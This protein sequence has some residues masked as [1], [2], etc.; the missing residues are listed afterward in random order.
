[1]L[2]IQ[3]YLIPFCFVLNRNC[4]VLKFDFKH[5]I[6]Y[7]TNEVESL[8]SGVILIYVVYFGGEH[9]YPPP[10]PTPPPQKKKKRNRYFLKHSNTK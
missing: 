1:M 8:L 4:F 6:F 2:F 5:I 7:K 3:I 9:N 10:P